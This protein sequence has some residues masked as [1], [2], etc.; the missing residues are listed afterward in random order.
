MER[1]GLEEELVSLH[2]G[3]AGEEHLRLFLLQNRGRVVELNDEVLAYL[4]LL[5]EGLAWKKGLQSNVRDIKLSEWSL[6]CS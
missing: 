2:V 5:F 1:S 3:V 6:L 4:L